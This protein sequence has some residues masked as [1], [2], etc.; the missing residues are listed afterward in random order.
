MQRERKKA[1]E[2][3]L[4]QKHGIPKVL[5]QH[6]RRYGSDVHGIVSERLKYPF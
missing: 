6:A 2:N 5:V 1:T 3:D 4:R